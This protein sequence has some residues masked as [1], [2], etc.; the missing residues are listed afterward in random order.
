MGAGGDAG[1]KR[2][3]EADTGDASKRRRTATPASIDAAPLIAGGARRAQSA[4]CCERCGLSFLTRKLLREHADCSSGPQPIS[5]EAPGSTQGTRWWRFPISTHVHEEDRQR[6]AKK[7]S[8][9]GAGAATDA[10]T[11]SQSLAPAAATATRPH[12]LSDAGPAAAQVP[13]VSP[14][15]IAVAAAAATVASTA[16]PHAAASIMSLA[17]TANTRAASK[18]RN[19]KADA[20]AGVGINEELKNGTGRPSRKHREW[21]GDHT[22][23]IGRAAAHTVLTVR[24]AMTS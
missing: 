24:V 14:A 6:T 15:G 10:Q 1:R 8:I 4:W 17:G 19:K 7:K 2:K 21:E 9:A 22:V 18:K 13:I 12:C 16:T 3:L 11:H 20:V 5:R 23:R